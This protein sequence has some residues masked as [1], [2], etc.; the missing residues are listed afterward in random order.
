[1]HPSPP[2]FLSPSFTATVFPLVPTCR[3][4]TAIS[5]SPIPPISQPTTLQRCSRCR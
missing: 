2:S 3:H 5:L 4:H 1:L